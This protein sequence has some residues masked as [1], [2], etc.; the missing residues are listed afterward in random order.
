MHVACGGT[1]IQ[2]LLLGWMFRSVSASKQGGWPNDK[3]ARGKCRLGERRRR[4]C[5]EAS[6]RAPLCKF[7][8]P[9]RFTSPYLC[10]SGLAEIARP[11]AGLTTA[12]L[13]KLR[14]RSPSRPQPSSLVSTRSHRVRA[15][16]AELSTLRT[17]CPRACSHESAAYAN[18]P[19]PFRWKLREGLFPNRVRLA[20]LSLAPRTDA[21]HPPHPL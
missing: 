10:E 20:E 13:G 11:A 16:R 8:G 12:E 14:I 7:A 4:L 18:D 19:P 21:W 1:M 2:R 6:C 17:V 5:S 9:R 15:V 3:F